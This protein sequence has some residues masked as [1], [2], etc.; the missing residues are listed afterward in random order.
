MSTEFYDSGFSPRFDTVPVLPS[1]ANDLS[2]HVDQC[3]RRYVA[4]LQY[5]NVLSRR[6]RGLRIENWLYRAVTLPLLLWIALELYR[7]RG[8]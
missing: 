7:M 6:M 8:G 3:A 1:E 4:L 2:V 5:L